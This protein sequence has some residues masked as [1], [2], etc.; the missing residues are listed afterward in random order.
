MWSAYRSNRVSIQVNAIYTMRSKLQDY[1]AS[2]Y[3]L[4]EILEHQL[5]RHTLR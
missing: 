4:I 3:S 2:L 5:I 1:V